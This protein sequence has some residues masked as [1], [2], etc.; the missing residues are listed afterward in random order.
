ML[1]DQIESGSV[2]RGRRLL[3]GKPQP[4]FD[5]QPL[6]D[7]LDVERHAGRDLVI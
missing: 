1:S 7:Y 2:L 6:R 5:K 3:P 4:S